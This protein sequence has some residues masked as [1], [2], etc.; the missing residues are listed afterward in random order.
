MFRRDF[1]WEWL[2]PILLVA[3]LVL[4][5]V[6]QAHSRDNGQYAQVDPEVKA[7]VKGLR[8]KSG[9]GCCD[10]ADGYP[11]EAEW[12]VGASKFR[13]RIDG[14]WLDVPENAILDGPNKLG[15]AMVWYIADD[16]GQP[17][18]ICFIPGTLS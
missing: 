8:N 1:I 13:V 11:A 6:S 12:D 10:T 2:V 4:A 5:W 16:V 14:K 7:W 17:M 9:G 15:Y 18:I 3:A